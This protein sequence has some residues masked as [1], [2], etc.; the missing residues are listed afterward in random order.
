M[1][2]GS[3]NNTVFTITD[4]Y[5][6]TWIPLAGPAHKVGSSGY[7]MEG[8][9]FYAP[10]AAT[11]A[12]HT[13]TVT[14]SQTEPL[15]MSIAALSGDNIYSPIDTYTLIAGDNGTL[16]KYIA[17]GSLTTSQPNDLLL[18][19][20]KGFGNNTYTAG[21]GYTSQSAS[22]G[23]NFSAETGTAASTGNYNSS[24]T[25]SVSD[26]WQ[27]VMA[28][29]APKPN[30]TVLSWT[31]AVPSSNGG[32]IAS[33]FIERQ[34]YRFPAAPISAKSPVSPKLDSDIHR[35]IHLVRDGLQLPSPRRRLQRNFQRLFQCS[36]SQ[37]DNTPRVVSSFA[38]TPARTLNWNASTESG[39]LISQYSIE[40]C[41]G[42]GCS[43][44]SPT[45]TTSGTSYT[46]TSA[47]AGTTYNYRVRAQDTNNFYGPYSAVATASIPAYFD[48]AAD[49]E[50]SAV[51][52]TTHRLP[53]RTRLE[54]IQ[55]G[56]YL[57]I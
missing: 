54:Q 46:D 43:N 27:T 1:F 53:I 28:A 42:A 22:T 56:S 38:A 7:P 37:P 6:N 17:S 31:A 14:L 11:G 15:V 57:L 18:G 26:F 35:H 44:F 16:A 3:H 52:N 45:A 21:A 23:L 40:R 12:G 34:L 32:P 2:L 20:V 30:E 50:N 13:I 8:E 9:F 25:A 41:T 47:A 33:Y 10:N 29:I 5:G 48:N 51:E 55:T 24:F 19:I 36:G 39:G 49:G 4:S